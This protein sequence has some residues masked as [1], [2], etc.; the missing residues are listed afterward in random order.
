MIRKRLGHARRGSAK[1]RSAGGF[2]LIELLV[3]VGI[4]GIVSALAIP[5]LIFAI[6]RSEYKAT[7]SEMRTLATGCVEAYR[8]DHNG[9]VPDYGGQFP[10]LVKQISL[11]GYMSQPP[12]VDGFGYP[13]RYETF[14]ENVT[15]Y[16]L[17]SFGLDGLKQSGD[18]MAPIG[19][20]DIGVA[21]REVRDWEC[22]LVIQNGLFV[23]GA[24]S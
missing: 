2:T 12:E 17:A 4:I 7:Q 14:G 3:V 1:R 6:Q 9:R 24:C 5:N 11:M 18:L 13:F 22:D 10:G 21:G 23:F 16:S 15:E 8:V 20:S 19:S